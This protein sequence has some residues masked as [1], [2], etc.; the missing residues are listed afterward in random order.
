MRKFLLT[1]VILFII[2]AIVVGIYVTYQN[3]KPVAT[4]NNHKITMLE[5][6]KELNNEKKNFNLTESDLNQKING[7]TYSEIFKEQVINNLIQNKLLLDEAKKENI[8]GKND[9][10]II[11]KLLDKKSNYVQ[12]PESA[13]REFYDKNKVL[14]MYANIYRIDVKSEQD[15]QKVYKVL[16]AGEDFKAVAKKY[17]IDT[18]TKNMGGLIGYV[19]IKQYSSVIQYDLS[20]LQS[21]QI[22]MP[23]KLNSGIYEILKIDNI[24]TKSFNEVKDNIKSDLLN[25]KKQDAINSFIHDLY[26]SA[27]IKIDQTAINNISVK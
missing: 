16:Q 5:Y 21:G 13:V 24:K 20:T 12:I 18:T 25:S 6:K 3:Y 14:Y 17:S 11:Q 1:M 2:S 22:T 9:N 23:I 7:R 26:K 4:I 10:D 15:A 19:P 8:K 27:K